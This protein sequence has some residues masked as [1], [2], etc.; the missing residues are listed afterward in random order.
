MGQAR[1]SLVGRYAGIE[2]GA[3]RLVDCRLGGDTR[4]VTEA[5]STGAAKETR[6]EYTRQADGV[7]RQMSKYYVKHT[8]TGGVDQVERVSHGPTSVYRRDGTIQWIIMYRDGEEVG[9]RQFDERENAIREFG[10]M[11]DPSR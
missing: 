5:G 10:D 1:H 6:F 11:T 2:R 4:L 8:R 7:I 3:I 9:R